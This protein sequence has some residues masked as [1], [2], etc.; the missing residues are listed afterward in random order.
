MADAFEIDHLHPGRIRLKLPALRRDV[1]LAEAIEEALGTL[2]LDSVETT[3][4]TGS[5]LLDFDPDRGADPDFLAGLAAKLARAVP[6]VDEEG[7]AAS[8]AG[9]STTAGTARSEESARV[10]AVPPSR[11]RLEH[12]GWGKTL[13]GMLGSGGELEREFLIEGDDAGRLRFET[14]VRAPLSG[15][16]LRFRAETESGCEGRSHTARFEVERLDRQGED[17][18]LGPLELADCRELVRDLDFRVRAGGM[19]AIRLTCDG[20]EPG[21]WVR[22]KVAVE[23]RLG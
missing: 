12:A 21:E 4:S 11:G 7:L 19:Y 22:G 20:F 23:V 3:P 1:G 10:A 17:V 9:T 18:K 2:G 14:E 13:L 5:V 15:H 16:L 8:L 6:G